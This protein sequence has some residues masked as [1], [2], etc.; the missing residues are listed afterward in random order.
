M[1]LPLQELCTSQK[2]L[3]HEAAL[4]ILARTGFLFHSDRALE[5]FKRHGLKV[6]GQKVFITEQA[7]S[8]ALTQAP[9][10]FTL[11][12]RN[13]VHNVD[14]GGGDLAMAAGYGAPFVTDPDGSLRTATMADYENFGKLIHTSDQIG[15]NNFLVVEPGDL[16]PA[17][18]YLDML[19]TTMLVSDKPMMSCP[20]SKTAFEDNVALANILFGGSEAIH[21]KPVMFPTINPLSPLQFSEEMADAIIGHAEWGQ[22]VAVTNVIQ[23]GVSGP[24]KIAGLLAVQIAEVLAGLVLTQLV[25]PG[26]PFLFG[27]SSCPVDMRTGGIALGGPETST[28]FGIGVQMARYY[29]LPSRVGGALTDS[30]KPDIRAGLE[31]ALIQFAAI[32]RGTD[33]IVH[34]AGILGSYLSMSF[35]KFVIDEELNGMLRKVMAPVDIS[36]KSIDLEAIDQVGP[37]GQHLTR[38]ETLKHCRTEYFTPRFLLRRSHGEWVDRGSPGS[39]REATAHVQARLA[40]YQRPDLDPGIERDLKAYVKKRKG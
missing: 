11:Q 10:R 32:S 3:L 22:P 1:A 40:A 14:V 9:S 12:A 27:N 19:L 24:I 38:P 26:C 15:I 23:G 33:I 34:A 4:A 2:D 29:K 5:I 37:G 6:D 13:Q 36:T 30:H 8:K 31:S 7:I 39:D 20:L 25:N 18:A 28:I 21:N 16:D 35:E 17:K